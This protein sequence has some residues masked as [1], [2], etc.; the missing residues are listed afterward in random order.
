MGLIGSPVQ[1][2]ISLF[3]DRNRSIELSTDPAG[4][5]HLRLSDGSG[6]LVAAVGITS[7]DRVGL[8]LLDHR[9]GS[10]TEMGTSGADGPQHVSV[11]H[12]GKLIWSTAK[13]SRAKSASEP[14]APPNGGLA[15]PIAKSGGLD[16]PPSVS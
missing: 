9:S 7:D 8:Q 16:R 12:R 10:R 6:Q 3:G 13:R 5:I 4:G 15:A 14:G 11:H 2:T 1:S